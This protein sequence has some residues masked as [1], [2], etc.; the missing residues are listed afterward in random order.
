MRFHLFLSG[1][2][3]IAFGIAAPRVLERQPG[4]AFLTGGLTLGGAIVICGLFS[5]KMKWHGLIGAGI[6]ALLGAAKG[7]GNLAALPKFVLG[8][9]SRGPAPLMESAVALICILLLGLVVQALKAE[10]T[11]RLLAGDDLGRG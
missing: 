9:R 3:I 10:S 8:D 1:A 6:V 2:A 11:N 5:L 7:L 4:I